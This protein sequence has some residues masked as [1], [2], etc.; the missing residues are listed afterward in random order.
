MIARLNT[1]KKVS[2]QLVRLRLEDGPV[3][4]A[5]TPLRIEDQPVGVVTSG[6]RVPG[7]RRAVAL[8]YVRDED[9]VAGR[10]VLAGT[11]GAQ[12]PAV[13]EGVAR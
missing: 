4:A 7:T 12:G 1:Y 10:E 3:P 5:G 2:K 13:I 9:A 11:E 8:G 6:A